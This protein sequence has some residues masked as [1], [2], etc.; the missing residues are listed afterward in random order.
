[1]S[2]LKDAALSHVQYMESCC[3]RPSNAVV[4]LSELKRQV[5]QANWFRSQIEKS[6]FGQALLQLHDKIDQKQ[7]V[8]NERTHILQEILDFDIEDYIQS[9]PWSDGA[10]D[11]EK[12]L[13]AGNL[14]RLY[15]KLT[16]RSCSS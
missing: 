3:G 6:D 2:D 9:L 12:T 8:I 13:V 5:D 4:E 7:H 15:F 16:N 1:M 11:Y 14:R 10:T